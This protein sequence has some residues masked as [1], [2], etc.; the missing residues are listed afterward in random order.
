MNLESGYKELEVNRKFY[1]LAKI[2]MA[3]LSTIRV[4]QLMRGTRLSGWL[5]MHSENEPSCHVNILYS[6]NT[7]FLA[8]FHKNKHFIPMLLGLKV[9][10]PFLMP[11][12]RKLAHRLESFGTQSG[13]LVEAVHI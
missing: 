9:H 4:L 3:Q 2:F 1:Q 7:H 5:P 8:L 10:L 12:S 6:L 13:Q 11:G